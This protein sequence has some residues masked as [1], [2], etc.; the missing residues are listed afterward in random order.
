MVEVHPLYYIMHQKGELGQKVNQQIS[1][2]PIST[3]HLSTE[4]SK[5]GKYLLAVASQK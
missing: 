5:T 1:Y 2:R 4:L 3:T